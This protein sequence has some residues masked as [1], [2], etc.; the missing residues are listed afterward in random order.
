MQTAAGEPLF[1]ADVTHGVVYIVRNPLDVAVSA[2]Y[3][4]GQSLTETLAQ[5]VDETHTISR[6]KHGAADQL[7]Q[8][9]RS[10]RGHVCSWLDESG[11]PIH[12]MR[13]E[14]MLADPFET[15]GGF[16]KFS[17]LDYDAVRLQEAIS[18]SKFEL[19]QKQEQTKGFSERYPRSSAPFF[20]SGQ[21]GAWREVLTEENVDT[22]L[23]AH[24][25]TMARLGY[26][27]EAGFPL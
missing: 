6:P 22:L 4:Y 27:N 12:L 25:S 16:V 24:G 23:A 19:L 21:A 17:G 3:H 14:D 15:F 8:R 11:L 9:V 18:A 13:Y 2:T 7:P 5:L 26:V 1:P 20:R 10:W